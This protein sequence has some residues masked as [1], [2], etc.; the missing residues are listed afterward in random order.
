S[1]VCLL[2]FKSL[3]F[4]C[5][6]CNPLLLNYKLCFSTGLFIYIYIYIYVCMY[7]IDSAK[8]KRWIL[9]KRKRE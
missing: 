9:V 7:I 8:K 1:N 3:S 5:F 2:T 4:F 6:S